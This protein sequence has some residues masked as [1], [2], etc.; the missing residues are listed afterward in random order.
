MNG[1]LLI[2]FKFAVCNFL[3]L[4]WCKMLNGYVKFSFGILSWSK[5]VASVKTLRN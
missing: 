2:D 1:V 5:T 3:K 4:E